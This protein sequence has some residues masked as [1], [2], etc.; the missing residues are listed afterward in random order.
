LKQT[1]LGR[2]KHRLFSSKWKECAS[3]WQWTISCHNLNKFETQKYHWAFVQSNHWGARM[4]WLASLIS[5]F[6][7]I[8]FWCRFSK[9]LTLMNYEAHAHRPKNSSNRNWDRYMN[10]WWSH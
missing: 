9:I 5:T 6:H 1:Y 7:D 2:I 3:Q 8:C 10:R 4:L